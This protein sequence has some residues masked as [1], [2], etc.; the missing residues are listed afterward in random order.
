MSESVSVSDIA[1]K[2]A[3]S[4]LAQAEIA[5]GNGV[6]MP[7][8]G[9]VLV[10]ALSL[11]C[12]LIALIFHATLFSMV[13][14]WLRSETFAHGFLIAPISIWLVWRMQDRFIDLDVR[15]EPRV[16]LLMLVAGLAWL[17]AN[18]V[19]VQVVQQLAF[20][21]LL[22]TGIWAIA[23]NAVARCYAFPLG[24]L[25]LA[26]PMGEGLI[27]PLMELTAETTEFLVRASGVPVFREGMYL[28]LPTGMWSVIEE[29]SGVRYLIASVTLGLCY[30]HLNYT[31]IWRQL[32]FIAAA[33]AM[34]IL[35]NSFRAYAL[36]MIGHLSD[37]RLGVGLDHMI[38]GWVLFGV[39]MLLMFWVGS[40]WQ[41]DEEP[42]PISAK[43]STAVQQ[44]SARSLALVAGLALLCAFIWPTISF[45]INRTAEPVAMTALAPPAV[46][47]EWKSVDLEAWEWHPA[48]PGADREWDQQY[49][50]NS[51]SE[52]VIVGMH[53]RQY[54]QQQQGAELI[55]NVNAWRPDRKAW[56]VVERQRI[57]IDLNGPM[58]V[59]EARV[60]S[61]QQDLLIWSWYWIDNRSTVNSYVVKLLE[62]KQ[63]VFQGHRQG[64][65]VFFATPLARDPAQ[66]RRILQE[67]VTASY[68]AV[69]KSLDSGINVSTGALGTTSP[70]DVAE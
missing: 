30:A 48:Q 32:T 59:E 20:V 12:L 62:A 63:K 29:C 4:D 67:F 54:L 35:A 55:E 11:Y 34:P 49:T 42:Q 21:A 28:S 9:K 24:F 60:V 25:F 5:S 8:R 47:G 38:F 6:T 3:E 43:S 56:R 68:P 13:A 53:L 44:L 64:T 61:A 18:M 26:V 66:A 7:N 46:Q 31:S 15:P 27:P 39:V 36:V 33:I 65:R 37:M 50:R 23:G 51:S 1:T 14:I 17:F 41:Q 52:P 69:T 70:E 40:F 22:V 58:Q 10:A 2:Q 16:L 57:S 19:D 45:A